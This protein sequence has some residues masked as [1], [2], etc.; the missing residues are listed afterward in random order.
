MRFDRKPKRFERLRK[1]IF[2]KTKKNQTFDPIT[3][4]APL[5]KF[6]AAKN[7]QI[8]MKLRNENKNKEDQQCFKWCVTRVLNPVKIHPKRITEELEEQAESLNYYRISF[9]MEVKNLNKFAKQ[10]P[11][12]SVNTLGM[13]TRCFSF[14]KIR[15]GRNKT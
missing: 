14:E 9:P 4:L 2:D 6:L 13:K 8:N 10:N 15:V 12:I 1:T 7:A 11:E 3:L 5:S